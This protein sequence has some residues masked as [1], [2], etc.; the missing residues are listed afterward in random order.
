MLHSGGNINQVLPLAGMKSQYQLL[1]TAGINNEMLQTFGDKGHIALDPAQIHDN[2]V[3]SPVYDIR[4][5]WD[6]EY[7]DI[8]S[9]F[10]SDSDHMDISSSP[11]SLS[12]SCQVPSITTICTQDTTTTRVYSRHSS[13]SSMNSSV[14]STPSPPDDGYHSSTNCID[15]NYTY[16]LKNIVLYRVDLTM[17]HRSNGKGNVVLNKKVKVITHCKMCLLY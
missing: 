5:T 8:D 14:N 2:M 1:T 15:G 12:E 17:Q 16:T 7:L 9:C 6:A 13:V 4:D 11:T 3:P 10:Y